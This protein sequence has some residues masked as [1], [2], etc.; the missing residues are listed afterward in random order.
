[1]KPSGAVKVL[2]AMLAV[3]RAPISKIEER[4]VFCRTLIGESPIADLELAA[5]EQKIDALTM[6]IKA[7]KGKR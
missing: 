1:M 4:Q 3:E 6:A 7:L 2:R 5:Q